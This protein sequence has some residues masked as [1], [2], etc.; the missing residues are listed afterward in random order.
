MNNAD[1]SV[2]MLKQSGIRHGFG[3]PS[4]S[5]FCERTRAASSCKR[6]VMSLEHLG[7]RL[8]SF[9]RPGLPQAQVTD[10]QIIGSWY[11]GAQA[12]LT[13]IKVAIAALL[14]KSWDSE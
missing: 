3:V 14:R 2:R 4:D 1:L 13:R 9:L 5:S 7:I 11:P 10:E 6:S 8:N 12:I